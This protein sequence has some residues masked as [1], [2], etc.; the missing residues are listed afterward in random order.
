MPAYTD[1][2]TITGTTA[3]V[4]GAAGVLGRATVDLC[5]KRGLKVVLVDVD[6]EKLNTQA[7]GLGKEVYPLPMDLGD[8]E[9]IEKQFD[10]LPAE[11]RD[12][13]ILINNAGILSNNKAEATGVAE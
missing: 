10:A 5:L 1:Q 11:F 7:A 8:P 12:I 13:D 4:T 2:G 9:S 6:A 3:L